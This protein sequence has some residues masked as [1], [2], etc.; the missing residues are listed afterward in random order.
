MPDLPVSPLRASVRLWERADAPF[1]TKPKPEVFW[2]ADSS[3]VAKLMR[4][5]R[6]TPT[7]Q[8]TRFDPNAVNRLGGN[9]NKRI[10]ALAMCAVVVASWARA[11]DV[12]IVTFSSDGLMSFSGFQEGTTCT[13]QWVSSVSDPAR[14]NWHDLQPLVVTNPTMQTE[15]PMFFRVS[16][17]PE[18]N[19]V[20]YYPFNG[21]ANDASGNGNNGTVNGATLTTDRFGNPNSAYS[22]DGS[23]SYIDTV[24]AANIPST[25]TFA[26]WV[27]PTVSGKQLWG[28]VNNA[29]GGKD[30]FIGNYDYVSLYFLYYK[31][32]ATCGDLTAP[33][34]IVP[35]NQWSHVV[36]TCDTNLTT[37]L[38]VNGTNVANGSFT[39]VPDAHDRALMI[40]KSILSQS[41]A[42]G[43]KIDDVRIYNR[44]LSSDDVLR[45]YNLPY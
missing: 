14:T 24:P 27:Y 8:L 9:M 3:A 30:G 11:Q 5:K 10:T 40:G 29:S 44:A 12:R 19:L 16:G 13:V 25:I 15:W 23:S 33:A 42:F 39:S 1:S 28:S 2:V 45:L 36:F 4:R 21:D 34:G 6:S 26:A 31:G 22:F 7:R 17:T 37:R 18:T 32:N 20:A 43:G 38:Y 41:L 35:L